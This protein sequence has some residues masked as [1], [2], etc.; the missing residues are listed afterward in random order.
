MKKQGI[1]LAGLGVLLFSGNSAR[2]Q[3]PGFPN[4]GVT[5]SFPNYLPVFC[6]PEIPGSHR[7]GYGQ[8]AAQKAG[9]GY[10]N[11]SQGN[12]PPGYL[13][14]GHGSN[15]CPGHQ[16]NFPQTIYGQNYGPKGATGAAAGSM[17]SQSQMG[18][19]QGVG[20]FGGPYYGG[21]HGNTQVANTS[22][23]PFY[24]SSR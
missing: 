21:Q 9:A 6:Q 16:P 11:N 22:A 10:G 18:R 19:H 7:W 14:C 13:W 23:A 3:H 5:L 2:A 24:M 8:C 17:C 4:F 20:N 15:Y 12:C 1:F